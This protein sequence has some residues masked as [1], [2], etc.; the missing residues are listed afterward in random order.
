MSQYDAAI[1]IAIF[2]I[3]F[4]IFLFWF[5]T[6]S[7]PKIETKK[8]TKKE[9]VKPVGPFTKEEVA[10]HC[11]SDDAWIIVDGK[12]YDVTDYVDLH[13][14]GDSILN[15]AGKDSS[16]GVHGPQHPIN[17]WDILAGFYIGDVAD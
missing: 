4:T 14:G 1:V 16:E 10:K 2:V 12:V 15:N 17:V 8:A 6:T 5:S 13:P 3:L 9:R 7:K 11:S